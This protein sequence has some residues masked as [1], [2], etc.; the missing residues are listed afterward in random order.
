MSETSPYLA[1]S[2]C[3][4][5]ASHHSLTHTCYGGATC[6]ATAACWL[7]HCSQCQTAGWLVVTTCRIQ[8]KD[9][10]DMSRESS[11][12]SVWYDLQ[13]CDNRFNI[14]IGRGRCVKRICATNADDGR[15]W[16]E[17]ILFSSRRQ[18]T[19]GCDTCKLRMS[20]CDAFNVSI[21]S[22]QQPP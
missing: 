15:L 6:S 12:F 20:W 7:V 18:T 17:W 11:S 5:S 1:Q 10:T 3:F 8:F 14:V 19:M 4:S 21:F 22:W 2:C 13:K 16:R 9:T